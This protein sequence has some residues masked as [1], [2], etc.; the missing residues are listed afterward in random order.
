MTITQAR[1]LE[2]K[3]EGA[4]GPPAATC[5][6]HAALIAQHDYVS[7]HVLT[8][9]E[10]EVLLLLGNGTTTRALAHQ[11]GIAERTVKA[12]INRIIN[13][14]GVRTRV[15]AAIISVLHHDQMCGAVPQMG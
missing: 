5:T 12:H 2:G 3:H 6:C 13:K 10:R 9:R 1:A 14:L 7:L 15:E 4:A 11:L 8:P